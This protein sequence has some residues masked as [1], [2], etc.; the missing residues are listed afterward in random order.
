MA[1]LK[2]NSK[3]PPRAAR[4]LSSPAAPEVK[5]NVDMTG[6]E[7]ELADLARSLRSHVEHAYQGE[8]KLAVFTGPPGSGYHPLLIA[9]EP[10]DTMDRII[11]V[12]ERIATAFE[13]IADAMTGVKGTAGE[14]IFPD[15]AVES[16]PEPF[17]T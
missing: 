10:T 9:L 3:R 1:Y 13:R 5:V 12:S 8:N 16:A 6:I 17:S 2:H 15:K 7:A 14:K 11:E 4:R